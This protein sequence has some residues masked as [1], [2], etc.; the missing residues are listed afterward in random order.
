MTKSRTAAIVVALLAGAWPAAAQPKIP[1]NELPGRERE[2]F[3]ETPLERFFR[4][5][6]FLLPPVVE[7]PRRPRKPQKRRK[8]AP[9]QP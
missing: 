4:P 7:E 2:R 3:I 1:A 6:P 8:P 9:K 5:G